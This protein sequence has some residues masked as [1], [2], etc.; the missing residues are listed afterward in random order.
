MKIT[1][2][3]LR[4]LITESIKEAHRDPTARHQSELSYAMPG[5]SKKQLQRSYWGQH[6]G[7]GA[8]REIQA[9]LGSMGHMDTDTIGD[10]VPIGREEWEQLSGKPGPAG[11]VSEK[12]AYLID[13]A[14]DI[15][16]RRV[17]MDDDVIDKLIAFSPEF[18]A[19]LTYAFDEERAQEDM[20]DAF[21]V[22]G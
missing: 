15:A 9:Q 19:Q 17:H 22:Y 1:R 13:L 8:R 14:W 20:D 2:K 6:R 4:K 7:P 18:E 16:S 3:Q 11:I 10:L 12:D 5:R 21:G